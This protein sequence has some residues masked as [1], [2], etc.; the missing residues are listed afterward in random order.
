MYPPA[1][2]SCK[3][4]GALEQFLLSRAESSLIL[5]ANAR[6]AGLEDRGRTFQGTYI[7]FLKRGEI[8][9]VA[10][11]YWN[12]M[13]FLQA[14]VH[15][16]ALVRKAVEVSG[17][18]LAGLAGP[19]DQ[20]QRVFSDLGLQRCNPAMNSRDI[21]FSLGLD[22]LVVPDHLQAGTVTCRH[23]DDNELPLLTEWRI[24]YSRELTHSHQ[25]TS[26][27]KEAPAI[28]E[29]LQKTKNHWVL[30][31][32]GRIVA[33]TAVNAGLPEM[34]QVGGVYTPPG[35]RNR[36]YARSVVAGSLLE[37]REKGVKKAILF[38]GEDMAAARASYAAL[39]FRPI[40]DYGLVIL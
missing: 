3:H 7:A 30:E 23:P 18:K 17:R 40:G 26:L 20:V 16:T 29:H 9:G 12:G 39:G 11:H 5:L 25:G 4:R 33:A 15:P 32:D 13:V 10:A 8:T 24:A 21:L 34:V 6:M 31:A 36:G 1:I 38:T 19:Y 28:M 37:L 35:Y 2:L 27:E 14:P 22:A